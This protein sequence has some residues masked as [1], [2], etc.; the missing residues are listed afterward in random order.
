LIDPN[1]KQ[2]HEWKL[3]LGGTWD[4]PWWDIEMQFDYLHTRMKDPAYYNDVSQEQ[5]G[6]TAA[7]TPI[8]DYVNGRDNYML[9]NSSEEAKSNVLSFVL[10]KEFD[11]GLDLLFGYAYTDAEDVVPMTSSTAGSNFDNVALLDIENPLAATSN[12]VVP[13]RFTMVAD[14]RGS[15]FGDAETRVTLRG[16]INEGQAQSWG[17]SG[18]E[19]GDFDDQEGCDWIVDNTQPGSCASLEGDGFFGRHLLYVPN[20][21]SDPNVVYGPD[22]DVAG[23]NQW[24]ADQ[25]LAPG[26]QGRNAQHADWSS[27]FDLRVS[28]EIPL[29]SD[30][31]G[32]VYL[33]VYNFGNLLN[34]DWGKITDA[35]FFTPEVVRGAVIEDTGQFYY[36]SFRARSIETTIINRSLWEARVGIDIKF[37]Q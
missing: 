13:N 5:V 11:M 9:T 3:A 33:K 30:F 8:Y 23:F 19:T 37:G 6:T 27:R 25:G 12:Y 4:M 36:D 2:P 7:G 14:W 1:Y 28:Q 34:D 17:M 32:R 20:G 15:L 29:G 18:A 35:V 26:F 16:Y 10:K 31:V 24:I 22:F 21:S